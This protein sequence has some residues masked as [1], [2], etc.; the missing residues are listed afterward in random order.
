MR[1]GLTSRAT[2]WALLAALFLGTLIAPSANAA[3]PARGLPAGETRVAYYLPHMTWEEVEQYL[4]T[5]DMVIIPVGSIEQHGKHLPLGSDTIAAVETSMRI[6]QKTGVLVAPILLA[7][8]SEHHMGF[9]GTISLAPA[10]LE[11]VLY[12]TARSLIAHGFK[13][14][15]FYNGH[16]GNETT[17]TN[18]V[19]RI[20]RETAAT[21][22]DLWRID[23]PPTDPRLKDVKLDYHAGVEETSMMMYLAGGLVQMSKAENP[24][25]TFPASVQ[26]ISEK[27]AG[28]NREAL[29]NAT[30]FQ[31]E[32]SGKGTSTR[33]I[34]SN[35][36][37]T[38]GDV[39]TAGADIGRA[40]VDANVEAVV[41][42]IE[43][44]RQARP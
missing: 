5:S 38:T 29:D 32:R 6:G 39:K 14:I 3:D 17:V 12:D 31:P 18:V 34:S 8:V 37:V 43:A 44:W 27:I 15:M 40:V 33:E 2:H 1:R 22:I 4:R 9:P 28:R 35:G 11:A 41:R 24:T 23:L 10:T 19:Y 16:G 21:A 42:F 20:N 30:L 26:A 36:V 13:R 7:G 25:L